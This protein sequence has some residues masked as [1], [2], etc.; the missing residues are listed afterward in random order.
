[1]NTQPRLG[2][3]LIIGVV[4][5]V[6]IMIITQNSGQKPPATGTPLAMVSQKVSPG[7]TL[8]AA[9][10]PMP[11][12]SVTPTAKPRPTKMSI[13][14]P[15][16]LPP[17][18][19]SLTVTITATATELKGGDIITV[20]VTTR[21]TGQLSAIRTYCNLR[22]WLE[23]GTPNDYLLDPI[24]EPGYQSLG[25]Y[26]SDPGDVETCAFSLRAAHPGTVFLQGG[27]GGKTYFSDY[28]RDI[29]E[30]APWLKINVTPATP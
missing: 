13:Q 7:A 12:A 9:P 14:H 29:G 20:V 16:E 15:T 2:L 23:D 21:N 11:L 4:A 5:V 10:S 25:L 1:M 26:G 30:N 8:T 18:W 3:I 17:S 27:Y 22:G 24:V 6:L 28:E 19:L